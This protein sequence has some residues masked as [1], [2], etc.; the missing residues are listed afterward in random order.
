MLSSMSNMS[1]EVGPQEGG[2]NPTYQ[3]DLTQ[4]FIHQKV[5]NDIK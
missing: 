2:G 3:F 4:S 5:Q 1:F